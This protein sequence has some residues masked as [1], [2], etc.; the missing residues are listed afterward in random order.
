MTLLEAALGY[1]RRGW[2]VFPL[3]GIVNGRCTC[4]RDCSSPGKHPLVRRGLHD[5]TTDS[6]T[7]ERWWRCWPS[8]NTGVVTGAAS[9]IVVIDI[10]LPAATPSLDALVGRLPKTLV[11]LTGGGGLHLVHASDDATLSN[12]AGRLPGIGQDLVGVDLRAND[13]YVVAPPSI[14]RSG[15]AYGWLDPNILPAPAPAWLQQPDRHCVDLGNRPPASFTG[16]GT[17]YGRA[18]LKSALTSLRNAPVGQRN[19]TLNR[20]AF[21]MAQLVAGGELLETAARAS[22]AEAALT[23]GLDETEI[24]R[25]LASAFT[26]GSRHPRVA[27]YRLR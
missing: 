6:N 23:T 20:V 5:A 4:G 12:S 10:D 16:A 19:H 15:R 1:A 2:S 11:G 3:H 17:A 27:P 7:I 25:T 24:H 14:H 22:L 18:A 21:A 26:A 9:G 8:A 13:G